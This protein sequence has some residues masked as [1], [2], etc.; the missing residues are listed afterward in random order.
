LLSQELPACPKG[1]GGFYGTKGGGKGGRL[2]LRDSA[3][4]RGLGEKASRRY[5]AAGHPA[6]GR[7][8]GG[9]WAVNA[10]AAEFGTRQR[11]GEEAIANGSRRADYAMPDGKPK[12]RVGVVRP[13]AAMRRWG[14]QEAD[15]QRKKRKHGC[16]CFFLPPGPRPRG[17]GCPSPFEP[18]RDGFAT[19]RSTAN[20]ESKP[21]LLSFER[22]KPGGEGEG[23]YKPPPHYR[24]SG[25]GMKVARPWA[26]LV[27]GVSHGGL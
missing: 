17:G 10:T 1:G 27:R 4:A 18:W 23:Q 6:L 8:S 21:L 26:G 13:V 15:L 19:G 16:L 25:P 12:I 24:L 3:A 20:G 5:Q 11:P 22:G 7:V 9:L 2:L 14:R